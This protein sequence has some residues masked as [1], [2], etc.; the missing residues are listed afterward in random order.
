MNIPACVAAGVLIAATPA[1]AQ[2]P[3]PAP[4]AIKATPAPAPRIFGSDVGVVLNFIKADKTADFEAVMAKLKE[5]LEQ[6]AEPVR[7]QQAASWKIYKSPDAAAG[8]SVLY[9]FLADPPVKG[10]DYTVTTILREAFSAEEVADLYKQY[11]GAFAQGQ[12]FV[13]LSLLLDLG[14]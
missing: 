5:A 11:S 2:Q 6:S 13:N 1:L 4:P 8:A 10:A 3:P 9:V 7:Q 14:Q 12:N